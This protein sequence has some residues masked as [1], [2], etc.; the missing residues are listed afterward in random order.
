MKNL[1]LIAA[2]LMLSASA[3]AGQFEC[4]TFHNL[5]AVSSQTITTTLNQRLPVDQ[6]DLAH[7]FLKETAYNTY[8]LEVYLPQHDMRIYSEATVNQTNMTIAASVWA[9]DAIIEVVCRQLN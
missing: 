1:T 4:Q 6:T 5:D 7:S 9:R 2:F 3:M 8:S